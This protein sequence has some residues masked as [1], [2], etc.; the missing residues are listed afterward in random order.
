MLIGDSEAV[1]KQPVTVLL[2]CNVHDDT[3]SSNNNI[4]IVDSTWFIENM[5]LCWFDLKQLDKM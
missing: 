1:I 4:I 5:F 2:F 3:A